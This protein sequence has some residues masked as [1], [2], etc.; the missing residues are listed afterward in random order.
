MKVIAVTNRKGGVGKSTTATHIAAGLAAR[1]Y[2]VGLVDTDSQG[3]AALMM[4]MPEGDGLF[5]LLIEK[6]GLEDVV[7]VVPKE[8]YSTLDNPAKGNLYIVP[9]AERTYQIP[10]M[11]KPDETFLFLDKLEELGNAASLD[12]IVIDTNPTMSMFDGSVYLAADGFIYVTECERLSLDGVR[13]AFEQMTRFGEQRKKFLR[14]DTQVLGI[15][16]NKYRPKIVIHQENV[17][18]LREA[19]GDLVW[20]EIELRVPWTEASN[21]NRPVF[22]YQPTG[23]A[24]R[25]AWELVSRTEKALWP[26]KETN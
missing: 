2:N 4:G 7:K 25:A 14:R 24:T 11:L 18:Q 26:A 19:F 21:F 10:H 13:T 20:P 22:V 16:P 23:E 6:A 1:G 3:H 9:S 12:V 15:V 17:A 8:N 5:R